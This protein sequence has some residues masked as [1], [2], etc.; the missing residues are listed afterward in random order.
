MAPPKTVTHDN[1]L[2]TGTSAGL[3]ISA[4]ENLAKN[5][6]H[7]ENRKKISTDLLTPDTLWFAFSGEGE[8]A[9]AADRYAGQGVVLVS[10]I[11][12]IRIRK[13]TGSDHRNFVSDVDR[14]E[15]DELFWGRKWQ[16]L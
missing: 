7:S 9:I 6:T 3:F 14:T 11:K 5:R 13:R 15:R 1:F 2:T 8:G 16:R 4:V 10:E 12:K